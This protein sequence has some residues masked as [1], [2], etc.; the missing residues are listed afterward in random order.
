[1][2]V[3]DQRLLRCAGW[4]IGKHAALHAAASASGIAQFEY[5]V[6]PVRGAFAIVVENG[7][8]KRYSPEQGR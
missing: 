4:W 6:V 8:V 5:E 3:S 1:V 7:L 2:V